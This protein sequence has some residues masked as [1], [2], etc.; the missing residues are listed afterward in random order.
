[1]SRVFD[2]IN[3]ICREDS[4]AFRDDIIISDRVLFDAIVSDVGCLPST[5]VI[6]PVA[7]RMTEVAMG[8]RS[9][10][11]HQPTYRQVRLVLDEDAEGN[12]DV[13][14][15]IRALLIPTV[16]N[17]MQGVGRSLRI[18]PWRD[19]ILAEELARPVARFEVDPAW[20]AQH[21]MT[22]PFNMNVNVDGETF[23]YRGGTDDWYVASDTDGGERV[24][25]ESEQEAY[26]RKLARQASERLVTGRPPDIEL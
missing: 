3:N 6:I 13:S 15:A 14:N 23:I 19:T 26:N 9:F 2:W 17:S 24:Q 4:T 11:S 12:G 20:T 5:T 7:E 16:L 25:G 22:V 21:T 8:L 1:M 18:H 10:L